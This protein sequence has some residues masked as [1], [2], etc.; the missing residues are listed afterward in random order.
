MEILKVET[1]TRWFGLRSD[2]YMLVAGSVDEGDP[3]DHWVKVD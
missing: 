3:E 1:R 2:L